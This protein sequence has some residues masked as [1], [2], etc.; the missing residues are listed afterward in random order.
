MNP[1]T[2]SALHALLTSPYSPKSVFIGVKR[3]VDAY[4][5]IAVGAQTYRYGAADIALRREKHGLDVAHHG[6]EILGFVE[7]HS[8]P[9][10]H[11]ILPVLLPFGQCMLLKHLVG[12]DDQHRSGGFET[13]AA[14]MPMIVS[15]ICM[16]RPMA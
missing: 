13:Y 4:K 9:C 5:R 8:V 16:S 6:F 11:L 1:L 15:P 7:E 3:R 12:G 2:S 14:L 10:A